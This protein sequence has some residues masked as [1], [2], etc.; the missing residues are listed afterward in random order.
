ME[1]SKKQEGDICIVTVIGRVDTTTAPELEN[2]IKEE[3]ASAKELKLDF[4]DVEYV[5]SAGLRVILMAQKTMSAHG[6]KFVI[7]NVSD[8][9][10]EVFDM[11]GFSSFLTFED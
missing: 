7:C 11:T 5:S 4:K 3:T 6:G 10:M 1:I 2:G 8:E 9:V